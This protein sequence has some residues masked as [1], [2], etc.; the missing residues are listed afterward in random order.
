MSKAKTQT[1]NSFVSGDF[2][3]VLNFAKFA[4]KFEVP[5]V[6]TKALVDAQKKN[7]EAVATVNRVAFEG[8]QAVMRR[9][10]E[11]VREMVESASAAITEMAKPGRPEEKLAQQADLI[12]KSYETNLTNL[13]ELVELGAKSNR[14]AAEVINHRFV[15]SIDEMK[16]VLKAAVSK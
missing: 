6:D 3:E 2:A 5:A 14:E 12:K 8:A 7:I 4:E 9:Q 16:V 10:S 11:I 13:N 15:D 1:E